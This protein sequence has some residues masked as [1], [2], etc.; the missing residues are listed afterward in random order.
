MSGPVTEPPA[1]QARPAARAPLP[2]WWEP[3]ATRAR[4]VR[5]HDFSRWAIP[6]TGG[7]RSAVL[8][9]LGEQEQTGPD[10]LLVQ[11][12]ASLRSHAGQPAF[13]GGGVDPGDAD[14]EA[15]ALREANEEVALDP[16]S[17]TTVATLPRLWIPV[18]GFV[19]TPVLAWWH[20]PHPVH[21][22]SPRE[23]AA[24]HRVPIRELADPANRVRV[25]HPSGFAG[26][27]FEVRG[28]VVWG[29]TAGVLNTLLDLGG[30]TQPWDESRV[31]EL[32]PLR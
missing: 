25:R 12:A 21:P 27:A 32:P 15:T 23:V 24:V 10:V 30:W 20:A 29:F 28:M 22:A 3:L 14:A 16:A 9:L 7:R 2:P 18:S 6:P 11:R 5:R 19:V 8:I 31:R 17:T 13:P 26:P 1:E 4:Q